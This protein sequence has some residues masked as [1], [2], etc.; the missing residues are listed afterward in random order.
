MQVPAE[1]R[2]VVAVVGIDRR[3]LQST[4]RK[5]VVPF[6]AYVAGH[7]RQEESSAEKEWPFV[8]LLQLLNGPCGQLPVAF[9]LVL[10]G[11]RTPIN[12][13][14]AARGSDERCRRSGGEIS[15][16]TD[17]IEF[18][19]SWSPPV[20]PVVDLARHP[21]RVSLTLKELRQG[22]GIAESVGFS[23]CRQKAVQTS[24]RWSSAREQART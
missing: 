11:K 16:R 23:H 21:G 17:D 12:Q 2:R 10:V 6:G 15:R 1:S 7:V 14:V 22:D 9:V 20:G 19:V 8:V 18:I 24:G 4:L 3:Q 5:E 13:G